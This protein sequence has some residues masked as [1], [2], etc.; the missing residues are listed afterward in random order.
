MADLEGDTLV[1]KRLRKNSLI[2]FLGGIV[3]S[4][5][6][7]LLTPIYAKYLDPSEFGVLSSIGMLSTIMG[8]TLSFGFGGAVARYY[9][10]I[11]DEYEWKSFLGTVAAFTIL[12]GLL[13]VLLLSTF[14]RDVWG[15]LFPGV[16][17]DPYAQLGIWI[18]FLG[19]LPTVPLA[20]EQAKGNALRYRYLTT[21]S[22]LLVACFMIMFVVAMRQ[23][24]LGALRA[25]LIAGV[26]MA[27]IYFLVIGRTASLSLSLAHLLKALAF[28]VP[29]ML[30]A[31]LGFAVELSLK[32][33]VQYLAG[34]P[35]LG[36]YSLALVYASILTLVASAINMAWTPIFYKHGFDS[37]GMNL[38]RQF[39]L[40]YLTA[41][42]ALG[43]ILSLFAEETISIFAPSAYQKAYE[44]VPILI[45]ANLFGSVGWTLTANP[46]FFVKRTAALPWLTA[47]SLGVGTLSGVWLIPKL[48]VWGASIALLLSNAALVCMSF[49]V[50]QKL[51][52]VP[53]E[54][55]KMGFVLLVAILICAAGQEFLKSMLLTKISLCLLFV[56]LV[57]VAKIV[58][59]S[60]LIRLRELK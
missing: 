34:L 52:P 24:A 23:G 42:C 32:Y 46:I 22:F 12:V 20:L 38:Y 39:A 25:Q 35:E 6:N 29:I 28:G 18:G 26:A 36:I 27:I 50:S 41:M 40:T 16:M 44:I 48:G 13:L 56:A 7:V 14:L 37:N 8:F 55:R 11:R 21:A 2:Y 10:E 4:G 59:V 43:L 17:F 1:H 45:L 5:G 30:Y 3:S 33:L 9:F 31:I 51:Y 53:Y 60:T 54:Y 15:T 47:V 49:V 58:P 57:L 19:A